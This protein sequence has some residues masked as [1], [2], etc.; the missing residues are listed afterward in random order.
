M[1]TITPQNITRALN[2][3]YATKSFDPNKKLTTHQLADLLNAIQLAP[4]SYGLQPYQIIVVSNQKIKETLK[5]AAYNQPQLADA[6]QVLVFARTKNYTTAH[7]DEFAKN[8]IEI[9]GGSLE[10]IKGYVDTMKGTVESRTQD[11]L[12]VWNSKQAY[13]AL[14]FLLESAALQE[15]DACPMEGFDTLKFDEILGLEAKNLASVVIATIGFRSDQDTSQHYKKVRK[16]QE[17][18]FIHI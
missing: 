9:R 15:I 13:I 11:E 5:D 16:S 2:W 18:L 12:A 8:I 14:G 7:V 6:S 1:E 17:D 10:D 3:R 4:S